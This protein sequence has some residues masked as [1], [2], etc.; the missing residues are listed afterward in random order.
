MRYVAYISKVDGAFIHSPIANPMCCYSEKSLHTRGCPAVDGQR[1][2]RI[3]SSEIPLN[4]RI[5]CLKLFLDKAGHC[6]SGWN[7]KVR[8]Y[9]LSKKTEAIILNCCK[10]LISGYKIIFPY[11][12]RNILS[13]ICFNL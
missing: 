13:I 11:L 9:S 6:I 10:R 4:F 7:I 1:Y 5:C 8:P 12:K 2:L 3:N